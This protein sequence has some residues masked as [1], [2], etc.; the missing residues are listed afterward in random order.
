MKEQMMKSLKNA[1]STINL[2]F[3]IL[4]LVLILTAVTSFSATR[5]ESL[6]QSAGFILVLIAIKVFADAFLVGVAA[7]IHSINEE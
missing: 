4:L 6:L 3:W 5:I 1:K 7:M 2:I